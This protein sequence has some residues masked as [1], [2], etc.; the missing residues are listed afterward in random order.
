MCM[1]NVNATVDVEAINSHNRIITIYNNEKTI[2]IDSNTNKTKMFISFN[3]CIINGAMGFFDENEKLDWQLRITDGTGNLNNSIILQ[4]F[5]T[6]LSV[7]SPNYYSNEFIDFINDNRAYRIEVE[8]PDINENEL[9]FLSILVKGKEARN[10][11]Y[12]WTVQSAI[13]LKFELISIDESIRSDRSA[14]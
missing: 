13:P 12:G 5:E 2:P 3:S 6:I 10:Q 11:N 14:T 8:L 7:D 4:E 1:K 9:Y